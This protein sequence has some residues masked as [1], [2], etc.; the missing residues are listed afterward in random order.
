MAS[1]AEWNR[2][3]KV[4]T[5]Y[6]KHIHDTL[7]KKYQEGGIRA[8]GELEDL[9]SYGSRVV[10][11]TTIEGFLI[12]SEEWKYVEEGRLP[13]TFPNVWAIREWVRVKPIIPQPY[14]LPSGNT[15]TPT[16]NQIAFLI[17]RKIKEDGIPMNPLLHETIEESKAGFIMELRKAFSEDAREALLIELKQ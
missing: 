3:Q 14:T 13:G 17:G 4:V 7:K 1:K 6:L 5:Q 2:V 12:L 11:E 9:M 16:E 8:S 10:E 15:V